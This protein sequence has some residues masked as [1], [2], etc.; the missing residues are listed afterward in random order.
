M[1]ILSQLVK[2][3]SLLSLA[4]S[5]LVNIG[6]GIV[7]FYIVRIVKHVQ[8][9]AALKTNGTR[10]MATVTRFDTINSSVYN[11]GRSSRP[12]HVPQKIYFLVATWQHPETGKMYTFKT[13]VLEC[14]KF[15][16]GSPVPFLVD[17]QNPRMHCL[18]D[19]LNAFTRSTNETPP[20]EE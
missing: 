4:L 5:L 14:D 11:F 6:L 1:K 9:I 13:P 2:I 3:L 19:T 10:V 12:K 16:I 20:L 7:V 15:P 17:Y 8:K 18:E